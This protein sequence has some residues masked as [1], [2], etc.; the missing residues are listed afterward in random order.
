VSGRLKVGVAAATLVGVIALVMTIASVVVLTRG[1]MRVASQI[2]EGEARTQRRLSQLSLR[3][4][5]LHTNGDTVELTGVVRNAGPLV[6]KEARV[7]YEIVGE[8]GAVI[9]EGSMVVTGKEPLKAAAERSFHLVLG[10]A[11]GAITARCAIQGGEH[12]DDEW[13]P[14]SER[15]GS[16][17]R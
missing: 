16:A 8:H 13:Y 12:P 2:T 4:V 7:W 3:E 6:V 9:G 11:P 5:A 1:F 17:P 15:A 14:V 10:G